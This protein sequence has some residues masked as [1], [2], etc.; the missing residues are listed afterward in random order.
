MASRYRRLRARA[1]K[2]MFKAHAQVYERS[3]GRIGAWFGLPTLLLSVRGRKSGKTFSTPLVYFE[4]RDSYVVVGSD[5]AAKRD[6]QWWKNLQVNPRCEVRIGRRKLSAKASLAS[7]AD[8]ER[9]WQIG[10]TVNPMWSRYQTR[11]ERELPVVVL[12]PD[13]G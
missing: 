7:G 9:L 1:L 5:G 8:R 10:K 4:D 3:G 13:E 6:P 12:T 11:T 2:A